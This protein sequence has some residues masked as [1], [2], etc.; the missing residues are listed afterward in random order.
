MVGFPKV[1]KT[2]ADIVNT[3]KMTK[4]GR[5]KKEEWLKAIEK[6][7]NQNWHFCPVLELSEDRKTAKLN[8]CNEAA[9][10]Q[11]VKA[12]AKTPTITEIENLEVIVE[13]ATE[14]TEEKKVTFTLLTLSAA[15]AAATE[16]VGV[17]VTPSVYERFNITEEELETM[18]GEIEAL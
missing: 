15:V 5:Y 4:R 1:L 11:K 2:R 3:F 17:P 9:V 18:K 16:E 13:E 14:T 12:G 6:L 7:E 10:G 8:F